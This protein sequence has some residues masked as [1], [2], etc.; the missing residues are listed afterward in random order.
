MLKQRRK[1]VEQVTEVLHEAEAALDAALNKTASLAATIP[2][3]LVEANLSTLYCQDALERVSETI[4]AIAH[5]RRGLVEAHKELTAVKGQIG[6]GAV[7]M[8]GD[9]GTKPP[10]PVIEGERMLR[11]VR[12]QAAAA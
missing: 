4:S 11:P 3:A 7:T 2:V 8:G 6:L 5:A 1:A 10:H 12:D 9:E